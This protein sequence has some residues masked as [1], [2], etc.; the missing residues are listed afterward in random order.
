[1]TPDELQDQLKAVCIAVTHEA[2]DSRLT[3]LEVFEYLTV[4]NSAAQISIGLS[5]RIARVGIDE[6]KND[7][8]RFVG[9]A[10]GKIQKVRRSVQKRELGQDVLGADE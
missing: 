4:M 1:M 5:R 7:V 10:F 2:R 8:F 3:S 9:V 6:A